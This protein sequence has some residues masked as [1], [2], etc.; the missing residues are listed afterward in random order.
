MTRRSLSEALAAEM[1]AEQDSLLARL[2]K[3]TETLDSA[4][5]HAE[6][7][8]E[9]LIK[10]ADSFRG[11]VTQFIEIAKQDIEE[12]ANTVAKKT[13]IATAHEQQETLKQ[14]AAEAFSAAAFE[15]LRRL[16]ASFQRFKMEQ[17]AERTRLLLSAAAISFAAGFVAA[18]VVVFLK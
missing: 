18:L 1:L 12:S 16:S 2:E 8:S 10:S 13:I 9:T 6:T 14:V 7:I 5:K 15:E 3:T 17:R 4:C 11:A